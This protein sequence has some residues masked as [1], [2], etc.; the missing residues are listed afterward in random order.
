MTGMD[1]GLGDVAIVAA[2]V[3]QHAHAGEAAALRKAQSLIN[4]LAAAKVEQH[5]DAEV[6]GALP[7]M[8]RK[9]YRLGRG[10]RAAVLVGR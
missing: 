9:R 2:V 7:E 4:V 5:A 3:V 8:V 6:A 1:G 10:R